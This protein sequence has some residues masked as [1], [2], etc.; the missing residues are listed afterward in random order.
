MKSP[1]HEHFDVEQAVAKAQE[2]PTTPEAVEAIVG[3]D[4]LTVGKKMEAI[5]KLSEIVEDLDPR[6]LNR[7]LLLLTLESKRR[8][9][10]RL[11]ARSAILRRPS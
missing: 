6:A 5:D 8:E 1:E 2:A 10:R 11:L 9:R 3:D 7:D 4:T